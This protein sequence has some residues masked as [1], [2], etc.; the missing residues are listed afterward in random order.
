[1][2]KNAT[3]KSMQGNA[4]G[5]NSKKP[6]TGQLPEKVNGD[7]KKDDVKPSRKGTQAK[8]EK[9]S[10]SKASN[11]R[12]KS[13]SQDSSKKP[14][15]QEKNQ[16]NGK[17]KGNRKT[18]QGPTESS[19]SAEKQ[20]SDQ[21][22]KESTASGGTKGKEAAKPTFYSIP[23][24][25]LTQAHCD[26]LCK[27]DA[28]KLSTVPDKFFNKNRDQYYICINT[29]LSLA[30]DVGGQRLQDELLNLIQK[31]G[32]CDAV[33]L[34]G[35]YSNDV[36]SVIGGKDVFDMT[37]PLP[38][39]SNLETFEDI[40]LILNFP[41]RFTPK[42]ADLVL[43]ESIQKFFDVNRRCRLYNHSN[44]HH[45]LE[46]AVR[47]K[48]AIMLR[49]FNQFYED[50]KQV[51]RFSSGV[52]A[53]GPSLKDKLY[54]YTYAHPDNMLMGERPLDALVHQAKAIRGTENACKVSGPRKE[55]QDKWDATFIVAP[56]G[57]PKTLKAYRII[58]PEPAYAAAEK[59]AILRALRAA[60]SQ[61]PKKYQRFR[62]KD[63]DLNREL[64]FVG[65]R[66]GSFATIDKS[67]ASDSIAASL[68]ARVLPN[69]VWKAI[70][71]FYVDWFKRGDVL[72]HKD[73]A[74][75]S[76]D[77]LCFFL[78]GCLFSALEMV[79]EDLQNFG[80]AKRIRQ[81]KGC[82]FGDDVIVPV[83]AFATYCEL[84]GLLG[85]MIN[86]DKSF[87]I[88][89]FRES[90]GRDYYFGMEVTS[91]YWPRKE[92]SPRRDVESIFSLIA[93]Q[94]R[95]WHFYTAQRFITR[96]VC[97]QYPDMTYSRPGSDCEDLW[98][99]LPE[100]PT[101]RCPIEVKNPVKGTNP[102]KL[103]GEWTLRE[104]HYT[105]YVKA[106]KKD[107]NDPL[108]E[109]FRYLTY[110]YEGPRYESELDKLLNV[111]SPTSRVAETGKP[112]MGFK[113][114]RKS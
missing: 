111:T 21:K 79:A 90:C 31:K 34:C 101:V 73:M 60:F 77:P 91:K 20:Q 83:D 3:S 13:P 23:G 48:L 93:L 55:G 64:A 96:V 84:A 30:Y 46:D 44:G 97:D 61:A 71:P 29:W 9:D 54:A 7:S 38:A 82:A 56:Q 65:S 59:Q 49:E 95:L 19:K 27:A 87:A 92:I 15:G 11:N 26:K 107:R 45:W 104:V 6:V 47:E 50:E 80:T 108:I 114:A 94:H 86:D 36:R 43:K 52:C 22:K 28:P 76:G 18:A 25:L 53:D 2:K 85:F 35:K 88:G 89:G 16:S 5:Q 66:D 70:Y 69:D 99:D 72:V 37:C 41:K 113:R 17:R 109:L 57:V 51:V 4:Q 67:S 106:S 62:E 58:C 100:E 68:M 24:Q 10:K 1:M 12:S 32:F 81:Y 110:L 42:E 33:L 98:G 103:P 105:S 102:D 63:Q 78:E 75:S 40:F 8:P 14:S 112:S 74:F 39:L